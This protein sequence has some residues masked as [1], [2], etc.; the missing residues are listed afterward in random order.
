MQKKYLKKIQRPFMM[1][2]PRKTGTE[3]N[4]VSSQVVGKNT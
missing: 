1:E 3:W 4:S 2:S